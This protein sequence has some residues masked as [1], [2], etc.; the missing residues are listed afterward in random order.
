MS[1]LTITVVEK[2]QAGVTNITKT[3]KNTSICHQS[4]LNHQALQV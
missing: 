2:N 1:W 4:Y 3:T